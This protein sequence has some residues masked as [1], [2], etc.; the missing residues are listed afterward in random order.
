M[1]KTMLLA[2]KLWMLPIFCL[3]I[4][5][6]ACSPRQD[7]TRVGS[8]TEKLKA[9]ALD[10]TRTEDETTAT[11]YLKIGDT[12]QFNNETYHLRWSAHP[13]N[14]YYTQEY[15]PQGETPESYHQ[16]FTVS[17]H[18]GEE[19]TP[20]LAVEVKVQELNLRKLT[21]ACCNYK[22]INNGD[23][24]LIDFLVSQKD[25]KNPELLSIVE[26]DV[27]VYRQ[28]TINGRKALK[29]DFY[30]RRAYGEDIMP[31]LQNLT[32]TRAKT[33]VEM[34]KTDIQCH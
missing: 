3:A 22:V 14:P 4:N 11:D 7:G 20:K 6:Q 21:D 5:S 16:M 2:R 9:K 27:H 10:S 31:F 19:I 24:Y 28:V 13:T 29:L 8:Q 17:V 1:K 34:G 25:E 15:F 32:E 18:Y 30:S 26:F 23:Y 33:I 12:L